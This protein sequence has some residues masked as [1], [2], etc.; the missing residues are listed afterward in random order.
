MDDRMLKLNAKTGPHL[1][2][3]LLSLG[4]L[5]STYEGADQIGHAL[6]LNETT[7]NSSRELLGQ[8]HPHTIKLMDDVARGFRATEQFEKAIAPMEEAL[9]LLRLKLGDDKEVTLNALSELAYV[10]ELVNRL[11]DAERLLHDCL[12]M[13]EKLHP[14]DWKTFDTRSQLG[15]ILLAQEKLKESAEPIN[16]G[17]EGLDES[18][19]SIPKSLRNEKLRRAVKRLIK[20]AEAQE[21]TT[22]QAKWKL[23]LGEIELGK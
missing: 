12:E 2:E 16:R 18:A 13:R 19:K 15:G 11:S 4:G 1:R 5:V 14:E 7:L 6:K 8:E 17:F 23:R 9:E 20:L 21:D 10:Y 22:A 3:T